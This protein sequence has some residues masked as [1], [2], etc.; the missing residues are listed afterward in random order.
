MLEKERELANRVELAISRG[1]VWLKR[2]KMDKLP[3]WQ[4][5]PQSN[6]PMR[7]LSISG[8]VMHALHRNPRGDDLQTI[9]RT[10]L[11]ALDGSLVESDDLEQSDG[12][13]SFPSGPPINDRTRHIKL[14][15]VIL[16]TLAAY[17]N[18]TA[19][20]RAKALAWFERVVG[21]GA[22]DAL[23]AQ[24]AVGRGRAADRA[25]GVKRRAAI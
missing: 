4:D 1:L 3:R 22:A 10:W 17:K 2:N 16:G 15:W 19:W 6:D 20:Q 8:L 24:Q 11:D 21:V 23:G 5:Y 18:G 7:S 12:T 14:P 9:D 13:V 25:Q